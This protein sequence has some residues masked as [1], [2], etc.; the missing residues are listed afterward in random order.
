MTAFPDYVAQLQQQARHP[1]IKFV[2]RIPNRQLWHALVELDIVVVPTL[3]YETA[4]LI[5]QEAFA[6]GVPVVASQIGA[7]QER[8]EDGVDGRFF[9]PGDSTA[10]HDILHQLLIDR[11]ALDTLR[12]GIK[13][14]RTIQEHLSEIESIYTQITH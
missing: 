5:V 7:L 4:S 12:N 2:G 9:P 1:G 8:L 10:L 6:C 11:A 3:W 13:P 14:V